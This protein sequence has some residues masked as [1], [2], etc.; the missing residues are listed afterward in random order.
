MGQAMPRRS[1][2]LGAHPEGST[3]NEL[4]VPPP[5]EREHQA[6]TDPGRPIGRPAPHSAGASMEG[7]LSGAPAQACAR[8]PA[9]THTAA[10]AD[11]GA[12]TGARTGTCPR[13]PAA[14]RR[15]TTAPTPAAAP[16]RSGRRLDL[17]PVP[18]MR[19]S[20]CPC[21]PRTTRGPLRRTRVTQTATAAHAWHVRL[22]P[23][24]SWESEKR[25]WTH[26]ATKA[27]RRG[28][29]AAPPLTSPTTPAGP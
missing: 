6:E 19:F 4:T 27:G 20:A 16:A 24:C 25:R 28:A 2:A 13:H 8:A 1:R 29:A 14:P 26:R 18:A 5:A 23:S 17:R 7:D 11:A 9:R 3:D 10:H 15:A 12:R 21:Q 22:Y